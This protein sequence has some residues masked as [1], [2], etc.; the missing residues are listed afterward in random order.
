MFERFQGRR[1]LRALSRELSSGHPPP[2]RAWEGDYGEQHGRLLDWAMDTPVFQELL[3]GGAALPQGYGVG[4]DERV[5]EY[6]WLYAQRPFG[7][8][9][10]AGSTLNHEHVVARFQPQTSWLCITTLVPEQ[11]AYTERGISYVYADLR[12]LPFRGGWFDTVICA[13][14]LEHV[15]MDNKLYGSGEDVAADPA[16]EQAAAL[17]ELLRVTAPGGRVLITV[18]YGRSEDHGWF[19]QYDESALRAILDGLNPSISIYAYGADGWR[20][21]S[22][23]GAADARF[24]DHHADKSPAPDRAAAARAVA[25][26]VLRR[27]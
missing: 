14:T 16:A 23:A 20:I 11:A 15:G 6:P 5:I 9:L 21:D 27:G 4:L 25:C 19:R 1:R 18:P 2:E 3:R 24:K 7:R 8:L 22:L 12:E 26:V 10:D 13:S 17:A